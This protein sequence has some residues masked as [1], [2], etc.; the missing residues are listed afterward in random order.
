M[1]H[2]DVKKSTYGFT[3]VEI[4]TV[5]SVM[6]ILVA[7]TWSSVA[8]YLVFARDNEREADTNSIARIIELYYRTQ[9]AIN[10]VPTYPT[11]T[12][13]NTPA[14]RAA[15]I[16]DADERIKSPSQTGISLIAATTTGF[17]TITT[18]QYIYQPFT[19]TN[20]ICTAAADTPC[21]RFNIFFR[22]EVNNS[23]ITLESLHQ[24]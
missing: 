16:P 14:Q 3:I 7:I 9:A 8:N 13:I 20:T 24:Q 1:L 4:I 19:A 10:G 2:E 5:M 12:Q 18:K 23:I 15:I 21:V 11:V 6:S 22:K 17:P